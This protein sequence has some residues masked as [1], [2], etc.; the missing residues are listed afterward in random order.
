MQSLSRIYSNSIWLERENSEM[1]DIVYSGLKDSRKLLLDYT[2]LRGVLLKNS[3]INNYSSFY[4]NYF[5]V[6]YL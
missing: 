1:F 5:S 6:N 2:N 3:S 4:K